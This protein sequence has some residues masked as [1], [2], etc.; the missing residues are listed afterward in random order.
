MEVMGE[1]SGK[2]GK[3]TE[4]SFWWWTSGYQRLQS[5]W[6]RRGSFI[7]TFVYAPLELVKNTITKIIFE[8]DHYWDCRKHRNIV[9]IQHF[10][11]A[12]YIIIIL[13]IH[14]IN[15]FENQIT[16]W[17]ESLSSTTCKIWTPSAGQ[18]STTDGCHELLWSL[19]PEFDSRSDWPTESDAAAPPIAYP[20][21]STEALRWSAASPD[22]RYLPLPSPPSVL[23]AQNTRHTPSICGPKD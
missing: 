14:R 18:V 21:H 8:I 17:K 16:K 19:S 20:S 23:Y 12:T 3:R 7:S 15:I 2:C 22:V 10:Q 5:W 1:R 13:Y 4:P 11:C 6:R 9:P